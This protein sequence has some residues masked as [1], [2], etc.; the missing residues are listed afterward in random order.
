MS[1]QVLAVRVDGVW[2]SQADVGNQVVRDGHTQVV[3][4]PF[5]D[6]DAIVAALGEIVRRTQTLSRDDQQRVRSF[7]YAASNVLEASTRL[8]SADQKIFEDAL[9]AGK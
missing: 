6:V 1:S 2:T 4:S 3:D 8:P 7:I 5:S 9:R